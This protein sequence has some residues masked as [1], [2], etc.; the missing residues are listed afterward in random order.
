MHLDSRMVEY[1][2][3]F[4]GYGLCKPSSLF[5][6]QPQFISF[7]DELSV[8]KLGVLVVVQHP[9][10]GETFCQPFIA[11]DQPSQ[12][13]WCCSIHLLSC[14]ERCNT[15]TAGMPH[16][17]HHFVQNKTNKQKK[18]NSSCH[19]SNHFY[20]TFHTNEVDFIL[21]ATSHINKMLSW[22][23]RLPPLKMN[24]VIHHHQWCL[25]F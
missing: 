14:R 16:F 12:T 21:T 15:S 5:R 1:V 6:K 9:P 8:W 20:K 22:V 3:L 7:R 13:T 10:A 17:S 24:G 18:H 2:F 25:F 4:C 19:F 11:E 23:Y